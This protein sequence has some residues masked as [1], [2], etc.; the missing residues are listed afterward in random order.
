MHHLRVEPS[1]DVVAV[2]QEYL[3]LAR[4]LLENVQPLE[5]ESLKDR[6]LSAILSPALEV[7]P[8]SRADAGC[9]TRNESP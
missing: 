9:P 1:P 6:E 4:T 5:A 3:G 8:I 2:Q 7:G